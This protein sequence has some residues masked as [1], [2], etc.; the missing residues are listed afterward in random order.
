MI[1]RVAQLMSRVRD[2][3]EMDRLCLKAHKHR[4][5]HAFESQTVKSS[6][7]AKTPTPCQ[8]MTRLPLPACS[9]RCGSVSLAT[10]LV[11]NVNTNGV[12]IPLMGLETRQDTDTSHTEHC[13]RHV[14]HGTYGLTQRTDTVIRKTMA[15]P[16]VADGRNHDS[17]LFVTMK[18]LGGLNTSETLAVQQS[19]VSPL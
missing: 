10:S 7:T 4:N 6:A 5:I 14:L 2:S 3:A 8:A 18:V 11:R 13:A 12:W 16:S 17:K 9:W 19:H 1:E 15:K